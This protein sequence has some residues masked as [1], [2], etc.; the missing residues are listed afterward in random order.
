MSS[1]AEERP[2]V[3][4]GG[5]AWLRLL[6]RTRTLECLVIKLGRNWALLRVSAPVDVGMKVRLALPGFRVTVL[7]VDGAVSGWAELGAG[8]FELA[9][10]F[11][12]PLPGA[13]ADG[14]G[15]V[16]GDA[17]RADP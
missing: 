3:L 7:E 16:S 17:R 13:P 1:S 15:P 10:H 8:G 5:R 2:P 9:I 4:P 12:R 11:D 14:E 6:D